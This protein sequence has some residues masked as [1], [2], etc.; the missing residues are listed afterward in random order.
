MGVEQ[1]WITIKPERLLEPLVERLVVGGRGLTLL[2]IHT[3]R[4]QL[5]LGTT[6]DMVHYARIPKPFPIYMWQPPA[7]RMEF[8]CLIEQMKCP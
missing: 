3:Q 2:V 5:I 7:D 4:L 8:G 6:V 1:Y